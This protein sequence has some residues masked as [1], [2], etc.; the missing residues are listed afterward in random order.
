MATKVACSI[1]Y[2]QFG[3][4]EPKWAL[5]GSEIA[6]IWFNEQVHEWKGRYQGPFY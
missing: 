6:H 1:Q 2:L 5:R 3:E 4:C